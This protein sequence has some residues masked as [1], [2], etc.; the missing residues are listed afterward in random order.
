MSWHA[1]AR[2]SIDGIMHVQADSPAWQ[3]IEE[4]WQE[5]KKEAWH[6]QLGLAIYGVNRFVL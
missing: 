1:A 3:P 5:L 4:T 2:L 6:L